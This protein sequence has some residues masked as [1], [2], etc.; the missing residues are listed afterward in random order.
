MNEPHP[1]LPESVR[2][3]IAA[4]GFPLQTAVSRLISGASPYRVVKEEFPWQDRS[5]NDQ[6]LDI[7]AEHGAAVFT[8]ECKKAEKQSWVFLHPDGGASG[9]VQRARCVFTRQI[10]DST[11]RL[12]LFCGD[13]NVRPASFESKFCIRSTSLQGGDQRLIE[14]DLQRLLRATD[15]Y[16]DQVRSTF[17]QQSLPELDKPFLPMIVTT[18]RMFVASYDSGTIPLTTGRLEV[19]ADGLLEVMWV[20]FRKTFTSSRHGDVG[21]RTIMVVGAH[22]LV[23]LLEKLDIDLARGASNPIQMARLGG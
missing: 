11:R 1:K 8:I 14:P 13:W 5:G 7:I 3:A 2:A 17:Q 18:A 16:A 6:F 20:R 10:Q 12:E 23:E 22:H 15:V 21:E 9:D 4:S 19:G